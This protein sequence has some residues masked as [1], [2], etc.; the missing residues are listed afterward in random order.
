VRILLEVGG[1]DVDVSDRWE[2]SPLDEARR[3]GAT[4]VVNYLQV[5]CKGGLMAADARTLLSLGG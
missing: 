5:C 1:A 4:P 2:Q 3:V